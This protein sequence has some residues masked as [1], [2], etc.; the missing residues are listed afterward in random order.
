MYLKLCK[1]H[2]RTVWP[3]A[4]C[5]QEAH[6]YMLL[7]R[8]WRRIGASARFLCLPCLEARL[9]RPLRR[10]DLWKGEVTNKWLRWRGNRVVLR[11]PLAAWL[12]VEKEF[13]RL[14]AKNKT[15]YIPPD[16]IEGLSEKGTK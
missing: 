8:L 1:P 6:P 10:T 9:H 11:D 3:C 13:D 14:R 2:D 5:K 12:V 4:D 16:V 7:D 15:Y